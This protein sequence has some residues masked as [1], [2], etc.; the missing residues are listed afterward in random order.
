MTV[1]DAGR[2]RRRVLVGMA[3][4]VAV[5]ACGS[6]AMSSEAIVVEVVSVPGEMGVTPDLGRVA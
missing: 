4:A 6:R 3:A 5:S 1:E 2:S